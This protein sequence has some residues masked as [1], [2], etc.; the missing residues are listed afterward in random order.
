MYIIC[1]SPS[2]QTPWGILKQLKVWKVLVL[3]FL[4]AECFYI[5]L[6]SW[7]SLWELTERVQL[8]PSLSL[9]F[10]QMR[11]LSLGEQSQGLGRGRAKTPS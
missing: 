7:V 2:P 3:A 8:A 11:Q 9:L 6:S 10:S 4:T 5:P 1:L